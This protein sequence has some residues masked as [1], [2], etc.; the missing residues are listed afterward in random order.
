MKKFPYFY[1]IEKIVGEKELE[2]QLDEKYV[3]SYLF[4]F[5][6]QPDKCR[7]IISSSHFS[8]KNISWKNIAE[9]EK[10]AEV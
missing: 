1:L 5:V 10:S 7:R 8:W 2:E 6:G 3:P 9:K 4:S